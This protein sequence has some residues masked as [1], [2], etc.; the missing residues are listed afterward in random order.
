MFRS[1]VCDVQVGTFLP[2]LA[3]CLCHCSFT[4]HTV[5]FPAGCLELGMEFVFIH[6]G[7]NDRNL[8]A[9]KFIE[10]ATFRDC[11]YTPYSENASLI[12]FQKDGDAERQ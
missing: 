7:I 6:R 10:K 11:D 5:C 12:L 1:C 8:S 9:C 4:S 2:C 3:V